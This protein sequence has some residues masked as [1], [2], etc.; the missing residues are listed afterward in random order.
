MLLG[1]GCDPETVWVSLCSDVRAG[2]YE[3][4]KGIHWLGRMIKID[5]E[6]G[7]GR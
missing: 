1:G 3:A 5:G 7:K 4:R 6:E 2:E